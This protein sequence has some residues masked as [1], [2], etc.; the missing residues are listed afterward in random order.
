MASRSP[1]A[2]RALAVAPAEA[3]L[4]ALDRCVGITVRPGGPEPREADLAWAD[5]VVIE[6]NATA[7]A[8][9]VPP[10]LWLIP[11]DAGAVTVTGAA[12]MLGV[13][14]NRERLATAIRAAASGLTVRDPAVD[15]G[16]ASLADL[17][18][19]TLTPREEEI[20]R[21]LARGRSNKGIA[22]DLGLSEHTVKYHVSAILAKLRAESRTE[23]V[24][25]AARRGWVML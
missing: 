5:V 13:P 18:V 25:V 24:A 14:T 15:T 4:T 22:A 23:A 20:L 7:A 9:W 17:D 3:H 10:T 1:I 12:S 8:V 19:E 6:A 2:V 16:E 21:L 11:P